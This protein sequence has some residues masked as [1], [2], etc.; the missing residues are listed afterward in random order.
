MYCCKI[1]IT[2]ISEPDD[3]TICEGRATT[4]TCVLNSSISS[5]DVQWYRLV[6]DTG[7][8]VMV[9]PDDDQSITVSTHTINSSLTITNARI[10]HTGY[11]WIRLQS[12]DVCNVSLTVL[13]SM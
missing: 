7:T 10:S 13:I 12:D 9:D 1:F 11:Y 6:G 2:V 3:D 4:F 8:T 5:G